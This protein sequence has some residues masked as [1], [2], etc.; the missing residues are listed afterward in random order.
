LKRCIPAWRS[1]PPSS[2]S[3]ATPG[4]HARANR[5]PPF[6][7]CL[8]RLLDDLSREELPH[9]HEL[10]ALH[11]SARGELPA[12]EKRSPMYEESQDFLIPL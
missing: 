11:E 1:G 4:F 10:K 5:F 7:A 2:S 9:Y 6:G 12:G 8:S 3:W